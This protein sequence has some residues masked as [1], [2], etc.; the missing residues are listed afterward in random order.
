MSHEAPAYGLWSLVFINSAVFL[1]FAF[2]FTRPRAGRNW[3]SFGGFSAFI[4]A[5]FAEM[6]GFP[7]TLYLLAGCLRRRFQGLDPLSHDV[8]HLW[9]SLLGFKGDPHSNR[10]HIL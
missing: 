3:R 9:Y 10:I 8:G 5:L 4:V 1:I 6:H 2:S 7:L